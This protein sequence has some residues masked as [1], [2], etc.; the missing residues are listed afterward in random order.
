M[1][2]GGGAVAD[3]GEVVAA[4]GVARPLLVTDTYLVG[5]GA[6]DRLLGYLRGAG[7]EPGLFAGTVPDSTTR[8]LDDGLAAAHAHGADAVIGF[9]GGSPMDTAKALALLAVRGGHMREHRAPA[10]VTGPALPVVAVPTTAGS[11]S[12][13][14]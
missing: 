8:S 5:T 11:G 14:T 6:A 3:I 4:L 12:E 7:L 13:A 10:R 2:I 9:G 1:R